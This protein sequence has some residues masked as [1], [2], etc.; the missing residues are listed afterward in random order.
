[1][2]AAYLAR[3]IERPVKGSSFPIKSRGLG[4]VEDVCANAPQQASISNKAQTVK[5]RYKGRRE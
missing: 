5:L 3:K 2:P 4:E 1:M